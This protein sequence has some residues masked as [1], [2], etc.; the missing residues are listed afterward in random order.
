MSCHAIDLRSKRKSSSSS[1]F[2]LQ[3]PYGLQ[4]Q[5]EKVGVIVIETVFHQAI[6]SRVYEQQLKHHLILLQKSDAVSWTFTLYSVA[7]S[8]VT[9]VTTVVDIMA[10]MTYQRV[11]FLGNVKCNVH[12]RCY[13]E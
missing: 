2:E 7:A 8:N 11:M 9:T 6:C 5:N 12:N 10:M 13:N 1:S 3:P 4:Y